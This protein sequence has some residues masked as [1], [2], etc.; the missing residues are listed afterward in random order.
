MDTS[1]HVRR[2]GFEFRQGPE[3]PPGFFRKPMICVDIRDVEFAG[4]RAPRRSRRKGT[5]LITIIRITYFEQKKDIREVRA[6]RIENHRRGQPEPV[7]H[8]DDMT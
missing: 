2:G 3:R 7:G 8:G 6:D 5:A 4:G 1:A